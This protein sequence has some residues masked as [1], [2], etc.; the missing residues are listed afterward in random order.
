MGHRV[1]GLGLSPRI[2]GQEVALGIV[3]EFSSVWGTHLGLPLAHWPGLVSRALEHAGAPVDRTLLTARFGVR[4]C[5]GW[6]LAVGL[7]SILGGSVCQFALT[8]RLEN[9]RADAPVQGA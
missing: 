1:G 5:S 4:A 7:S 8:R 2:Q 9:P 3:L 6:V